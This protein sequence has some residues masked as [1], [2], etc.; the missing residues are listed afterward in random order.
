MSRKGEGN[1]V[2][3]FLV[4]NFFGFCWDFVLFLEKLLR[5]CIEEGRDLI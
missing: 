1:L 4:Y 3:Y 2:F 5:G